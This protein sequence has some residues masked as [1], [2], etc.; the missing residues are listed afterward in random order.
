MQPITTALLPLLLALPLHAQWSSDPNANLAIGD[1]PAD[2]VNAKI[3]ADGQGGT[4]IGWFDH[5]SGNYD[6][7]VQHVDAYGVESFAHNGLL[8]SANPSNTSLVDWDLLC[9]S[10]G[11]CVIVFSDARAGSDLDV[12]A[13]RVDAAG[14]LTW[15]ANGVT[16]SNNADFEPAPRVCELSDGNFAV[17][18]MRSPSPG[19]NTIRMQKLDPNGVPQFAAEG[20]PI[21][22]APGE[23]PGFCDV[24]PSLAGG[25]VVQWLRHIAITSSTRH[26]RAQRFDANGSP[27]WASFVAVYDAVSLPIAYQPI[28]Q[29]DGAGGAFLCWHRSQANVYDGLVQHLDANGIELFP[30]NGVSVSNQANTWELEP[31]LAQVGNGEVVVAFNR[32]N[33]GQSNWGVGAQKLDASGALLWGPTGVDLAPF[34]TINETFERCVSDGQG[35]AIALWFEQPN[36]VP[37][38]RVRAQHVDAA[39]NVLWTA[40]G[41][42][43]CSNLSSK[44]DL[45]LVTDFPGYARAAWWDLRVDA[46]NVYA[47]NLFAN[48]ALGSAPPGAAFCAGDGFDPNVT[49]PCPCGNVGAPGHGCASSFN[50]LGATATARGFVP[51]DDVALDGAGMNAT[52]SCI[53]LMGTLEDP[54]GLPFGDGVRC[55]AGTLVRLR[56]QPLAAGASSFPDT[57]TTIT[58]SA[59]SGVVVGSGA[60]RNYLVYYRNAS[61]AFCPPETFNAT[62][63]FRIV[64]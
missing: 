20:L 28:V 50:A 49:T 23:D 33:P 29:A 61:A 3:A 55:A 41:I 48:G 56:T 5:A 52:G 60:E 11:A 53:F 35:G 47:Q 22:G 42:E 21:A 13:Y 63:G 15:G 19:D 34:D 32:R 14:A 26:L 37:G 1:R 59:R 43:A 64:W 57:N 31:S 36:A 44:D 6:V 46:G 4:W 25:Y 45:E 12:Y 62:N 18:W 40:G 24:V 51:L 7:Y 27:A 58:L 39:G 8:V 10:N 16:L 2:Q 9:D 30:H 17:V 38:T 54:F